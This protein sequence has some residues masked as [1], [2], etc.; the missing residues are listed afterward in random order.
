MLRTVNSKCTLMCESMIREMKCSILA[1]VLP[2]GWAGLAGVG[3]SLAADSDPAWKRIGPSFTPPAEFAN[4]FG[5]YKSPLRF[6]DGRDVKSA[7]DWAERRE[8]ILRYWHKVM[9]PWPSLIE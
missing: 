7:A 4:D 1:A 3:Q 9:G 8:E 5:R 6:D 2:T